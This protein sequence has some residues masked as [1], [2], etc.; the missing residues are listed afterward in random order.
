M[1]TKKPAA[2]GKKPTKAKAPPMRKRRAVPLV[3]SGE[4]IP[5]DLVDPEFLTEGELLRRERFAQAY[6]LHGTLAKAAMEAGFQCTTVNSATVVGHRI[7]HEPAVRARI[8]EIQGQLVN[9]IGVTQERVLLELARVAFLDPG[10]VMDDLG[11]RALHDIPEETR[12][13]VAS[14]KSKRR[15]IPGNEGAPDMEEEEREVRFVSKDAA[16]DKLSRYLGMYEKEKDD[17]GLTTEDFVKALGE[18][19]ARAA[20][21]AR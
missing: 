19:I 1:A 15:I 8:K 9:R 17:K 13:V 11:V 12:R 5:P 6:V 3:K 2:K 4:D 18:G 20:N 16:L 14:Y 7:Y 10:E 21:R